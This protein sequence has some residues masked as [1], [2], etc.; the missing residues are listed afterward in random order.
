MKLKITNKQ[1]HLRN[2]KQTPIPTIY[3]QETKKNE[4]SN[5]NCVEIERKNE[6]NEEYVFYNVHE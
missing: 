3:A 2:M 1:K 5:N 4:E 6:T